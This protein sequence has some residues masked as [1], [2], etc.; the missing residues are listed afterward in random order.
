M[1]FLLV[2]ENSVFADGYKIFDKVWT[3]DGFKR[4]SAW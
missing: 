2:A 4:D 3:D 1:V